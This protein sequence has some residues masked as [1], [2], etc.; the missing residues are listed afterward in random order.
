MLNKTVFI[1]MVCL[2]IY[3]CKKAEI[4]LL[5]SSNFPLKHQ[6]VITSIINNKNGTISINYGNVAALKVANEGTG[7]H[8]EGECYTLI[9]YKQKPMPHWYGTNMNSDI[10]SV[11]TVNIVQ[12]KAGE[13][14]YAYK[15]KSYTEAGR[16]CRK[17][18]TL[19]R[20]KFIIGQP[21]AVLPN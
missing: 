3:S 9:T 12:H 6:K 10:L 18:N 20:I 21:A 17:E 2:T 5:T 7:K 13:I 19:K 11:E 1:F 16:P 14:S 8:L 4:P 15:S